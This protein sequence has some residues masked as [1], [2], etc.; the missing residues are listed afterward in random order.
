MLILFFSFSIFFSCW[1]TMIHSVNTSIQARSS[2]TIN[3]SPCLLP[4]I[5]RVYWT[6][7]KH[8]NLSSPPVL[9][10]KNQTTLLRR[11]PTNLIYLLSTLSCNSNEWIR[12]SKVDT[13][14][15][16]NQVPSLNKIY[17]TFQNFFANLIFQC[18][19]LQV[20]VT[21]TCTISTK[22]YM[23]IIFTVT[24]KCKVFETYHV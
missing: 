4:K 5:D 22:A 18:N 19:S 7:I 9:L 14:F 17:L 12:N 3:T 24:K 16:V 11:L 13:S 20:S 8:W 6:F 21:G 10:L 2:P 23:Y 15:T 1:Q